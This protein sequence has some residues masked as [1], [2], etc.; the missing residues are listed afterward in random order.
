MKPTQRVI[1]ATL[2]LR[3]FTVPLL[4]ATSGAKANTV[5]SVLSRHR[6]YFTKTSAPTGGRGGQ[7]QKWTVMPERRYQLIELMQGLG[8]AEPVLQSERLTLSEGGELSSSLGQRTRTPEA[9]RE[10]ATE[11][12]L[13]QYD[14]YAASRLLP[15]LVVRLVLTIPSLIDFSM[16]TGFGIG[17][18]SFDGRVE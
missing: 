1:A 14:V 4:V 15:E 7:L 8:T 11:D 6:Q 18:P 13:D 2:D 12:E 16:R 10:L 5:R 3:T 17:F 9:F